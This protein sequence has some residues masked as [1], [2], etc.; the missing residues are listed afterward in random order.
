[1]LE[2][3]V[4]EVKMLLAQKWTQFIDLQLDYMRV[5]VNVMRRN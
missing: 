1:M 2:V 5:K 4:L 3:T